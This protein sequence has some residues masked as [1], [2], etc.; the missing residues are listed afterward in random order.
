MPSSLSSPVVAIGELLWD[1]LPSGARLG[2]TTTN[3]AVFSARLGQSAA[4]VSRL[5][6][7]QLGNSARQLLQQV[8]QDPLPSG[9]PASLSLAHIQ[10]GDDLPTGTVAVVLRADGAPR[11]EIAEPVAWDCITLSPELLDLARHATVI[12]FGTLAQREEVSRETIRGFIAAAGPQCVRVCDLNLRSPFCT[13]D[14]LRW[15]LAHTDI[16]KV[17]DEEL[18]EVARLLNQPALAAGFPLT[19]PATTDQLADASA[20][21]LLHVASQCRLVAITLGAHGS[22]LADRT[23]TH[24]HPGFPTHVVD[25]VGAGDAFTAGLIHAFLADASLAQM[26]EVANLCGSFVASQPGASPQLT[27]P[28]L[29]RIHAALA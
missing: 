23:H 13:A 6:N 7:D 2:G 21:A 3:F 26:S 5:G 20:S 11:Y 19:D 1:L 22:F 17:S 29:A 10:T 14:V 27:P 15:C 18:P 25:T 8:A 16:L 12:C 4:L 28:I 9:A 24:R